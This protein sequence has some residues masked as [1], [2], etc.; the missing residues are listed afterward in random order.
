MTV[1]ATPVRSRR[2]ALIEL[3]IGYLLILIVLWTPRTAQRPVYIAAI[4]WITLATALSFDGTKTMGLEAPPRRSLWIVPAALALA[5]AAI[6]TAAALGTLNLP[7]TPLLFIKRYWGYAIWACVQQF[8][9]QDFFLLRLARILPSKTTAIIAAALLFSL[10][11]LPSPIL[12]PITLVWG[13]AT[14]LLFVR[15]RN[16]YSIAIAHAILGITVALTIPGPVDHNMRVGLGYLTYHRHHHLSQNP[17]TVST[18]ACVTAEA[19][20]LRSARH[21]L[22]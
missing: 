5:I 13:L 17:H 4:L 15:Y 16:L 6:A 3:A 22:P 18:S 20:T 19:P 21:A 7:P 2:R 11:H 12:T 8:L 1:D 9:L 10:A 14:C